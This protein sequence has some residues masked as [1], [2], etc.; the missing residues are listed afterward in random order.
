M[1]QFYQPVATMDARMY[2]RLEGRS[3]ET[4]PPSS[5]AVGDRT[6]AL[7]DPT[8]EASSFPQ[9]FGYVANYLLTSFV[10]ALFGAIS[11]S[12]GVLFDVKNVLHMEPKG[13]AT[14][15]GA[16][17][18]ALASPL[19]FI[20]SLIHYHHSIRYTDP[21]VNDTDLWMYHKRVFLSYRH[22]FYMLIA[23]CLAGGIGYAGTVGGA[24]ILDAA[25]FGS[26]GGVVFTVVTLIVLALC[27]TLCSRRTHTTESCNCSG[28][29]CS[30]GDCSGCV[31]VL[32]GVAGFVV[33]VFVIAS[34]ILFIITDE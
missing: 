4:S 10:C 29:D 1:A 25:G 34:V 27:Y 21:P 26:A 13:A 2:E 22:L 14:L 30:G 17:G 24:R 12:I 15:Q 20:A 7:S 23:G 5:Q 33:A 3:S 31:V 8:Y 19:P 32:I 9:I 16:L 28:C 6:M 11:F 18:G